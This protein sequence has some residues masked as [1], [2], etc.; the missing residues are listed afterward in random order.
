M[1]STGKVFTVII[2]ILLF[3]VLGLGITWAVINADKVKAGMSGSALYTEEDLENAHQDGYNEAL[4]NEQEYLTLINEYRDTITNLTDTVS[5]L[6]L[7]IQTLTT[8]NSNYE[9]QIETLT[10]L[11]T[12]NEATISSLNATIEAN[13]TTIASNNET[14]SSLTA[15]VEELE[16][17]KENNLS[18]INSLNTQITNLQAVNTQLENTNTSNLSTI[19]TLN[20]QIQSLNSQISDLIYSSSNSTSIIANLNAQ[21][22][23]LEDSIAYYESVISGLTTEGK[24]AVTFEFNGS[25]HNVQ[26]VPAGSTISVTTPTSTD[27]VI[28]NYWTIN[29]EQIDLSS[30]TFSTSTKVVANVTYKYDVKF[31]VDETTTHNAQIVTSGTCA[32]LPEEP[33][34]IGYEF[35]GWSID[36]V[37]VIENISTTPV[38]GSV[39]YNALFTKL[40]TVTFMI[41]NEVEDTQTIRN[42]EY[43]T[44]VSIESTTYKVFNG[45][46]LNGA[47]VDISTQKIVADTTFI[48]SFTYKYD[49]KFM[50][51]QTEVDSQIV[52]SG[53]FATLPASPTKEGYTFKGWSLIEGGE[54]VNNIE[55][56]AVTQN[57]TYYAVFE[58][59]TYTVTFMSNGSVYGEVQTISHGSYASL[60]TAPIK[61]YFVF[62]G[63]SL[64]ENGEIVNNIESVAVTQNTTYYAIFE[65]TMNG[66]FVCNSE[67]FSYILRVENNEIVGEFDLPPGFTIT[68][69]DKQE[70]G[71]YY[72]FRDGDIM[73][74]YELSYNSSNDSWV[75]VGSYSDSGTWNLTRL[76]TVPNFTVTFMNKGSVY[77]NIETLS[78][79]SF[80]EFPT[81]PTKN[82]YI[83]KGWSLTENG[84]IVDTD[85]QQ[86]FDNLVYYAVFVLPMDGT[87]KY[88]ADSSLAADYTLVIEDGV[89]IE[90]YSI[91]HDDSSTTILTESNKQ[92]DGSYYLPFN[93]SVNPVLSYTLTFNSEEDCWVLKVAS[94]LR[95]TDSSYY[96]LLR[97]E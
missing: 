79:G 3:V 81:A 45:W 40:H 70:D 75:L 17:D 86:V 95:P 20:S 76:A 24:V 56:L 22:D 93:N 21:I 69:A 96:N 97:V 31:M 28:F 59:N 80:V 4:E 53:S 8:N 16:E 85:N 63:W 74:Q 58:I 37:N 89:L 65:A 29:G 43:A 15:Q 46:T 6:N 68:E 18:Q 71:S 64:T 91:K 35:D 55:S 87:F 66:V 2:S 36:G 11:K 33:T 78:C 77:G 84:E 82:G 67:Y 34:K 54:I 72:V 14:I 13:N 83:F 52:T 9:K 90:C 61:E 5:Q 44:N 41:E 39:T 92:E 7:Q 57:V 50:N 12:Q 25:V 60:P 51:G 73:F 32:V 47:L 88:V 49:V 1:S 42:G 27:Y 26:I 48:A 62:E 38:T 10:N 19:A 23:K 30:Y 94:A